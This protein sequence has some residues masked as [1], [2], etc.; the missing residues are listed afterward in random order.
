MFNVQAGA[1]LTFSILFG[2]NQELCLAYVI[3]EIS[4]KNPSRNVSG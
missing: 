2:E 4:I 1:T 3:F